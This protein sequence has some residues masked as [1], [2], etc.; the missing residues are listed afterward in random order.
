MVCAACSY[1]SNTFDPFL[2][3]SLEIK[4]CS[5]INDA[6]IHFTKPEVLDSSNMYKCEKYVL[7][8]LRLLRCVLC[9]TISRRQLAD[10][11]SEVERRSS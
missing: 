1:A 5:S 11:P 2:D 7:L 9:L 8:L 4:H 6:L 3:L 10:A